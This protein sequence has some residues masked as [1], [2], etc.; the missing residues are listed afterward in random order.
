MH[1]TGRIHRPAGLHFGRYPPEHV[2][3]LLLH[4]TI[5]DLPGAT[6][7]SEVGDVKDRFVV[8]AAES[9]IAHLQVVV[10]DPRA[11]HLFETCSDAYQGLEEAPHRA[12]L[13]M[14]IVRIPDELQDD[15]RRIMAYSQRVR[16]PG[17]FRGIGGLGGS[18]GP[19]ANRGPRDLMQA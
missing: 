4:I 2:L 7:E 14:L 19:N 10:N 5:C 15:S 16:H 12:L 1:V 8:A 3:V 13:E 17:P 9:D 11:M 6:R 18:L